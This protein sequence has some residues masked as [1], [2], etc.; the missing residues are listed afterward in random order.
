MFSI[1]FKL[2]YAMLADLR[3]TNTDF[4]N[5]IYSP[6]LSGH[7]PVTAFEQR[8]SST[9]ACEF[10]NSQKSR[11][12][13]EVARSRCQSFSIILCRCYRQS[14]RHSGTGPGLRSQTSSDTRTTGGPSAADAEAGGSGRRLR[15]GRRERRR[16]RRCGKRA[17]PGPAFGARVQQRRGRSSDRRRPDDRRDEIPRRRRV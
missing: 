4:R 13:N 16:R 6:D 1:A 9:D 15:R 11:S 8:G 7:L 2:S 17:C 14:E 5:L 3:F 10:V 12:T